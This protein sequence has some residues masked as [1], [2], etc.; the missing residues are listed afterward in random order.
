[1]ENKQKEN[2]PHRAAEQLSLPCT[3]IPGRQNKPT[4]GS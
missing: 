1:M 3:E 2:T 4:V